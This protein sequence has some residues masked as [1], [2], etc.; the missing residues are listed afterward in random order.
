MTYQAS[1]TYDSTTGRAIAGIFVAGV[2]FVLGYTVVRVSL[3]QPA[4]SSPAPEL[5]E[6]QV[7]VPGEGTL[8]ADVGTSY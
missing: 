1:S 8:W 3:A 6:V 5:A 4:A 2:M 7:V